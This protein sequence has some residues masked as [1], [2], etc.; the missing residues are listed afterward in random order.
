MPT[1]I[2]GGASSSGIP[3]VTA[4]YELRVGLETDAVNNA[5]YIGAVKIFSENDSGM[6]TGEPY[7]LSPETDD[8]YR[9]R[10]S[11]DTILDDEL[12]NYTSQNTG[13]HTIIA[14]ATNLAP[15]W[16]SGGYNTNPTSV[17]SNTS[18]A[19]LQ[20]YS[21]FPLIGTSTLSLDFECSFT[22]QPVSNTIIDIGFFLG[23]AT[24]PFAPTDGIYFRLTSAG[25][26]GIVN[27]N[28]NEVS[29]GIFPL[30]GGTGTWVYTNS[31]QYQ[32]I[33][34]STI[35]KIEFWVN[36][37]TGAKLLGDIPTPVGQGT[38][39]MST[40]L[41]FRIRH[42][43]AGGAASG[44]INCILTRYNVRI[45]GVTGGSTLSSFSDRCLGSYQGLSGGIIGSLMV[46]TVSSGTVNQPSPA[47]PTN[48]TNT[49]GGLGLGGTFY[50]LATLAAG[51][52][53]IINTYQVPLGT[54]ASQGRRLVVSGVGI[55][56]FVQTVIATGPYCARFYIAFGHTALSLATT[57]SSTSKAPRRIMTPMVQLVTLNQAVSTLVAQTT[58]TFDLS[59][60][61]YVNP[62]EYIALVT[63]HI[64]TAATGGVI[65]H[66]V[67]WRYGWE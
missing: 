7:L 9:L 31:K 42:A 19:T 44:A 37:G 59:D 1:K 65:A 6:L 55:A 14:A 18:G 17:T 57:E 45:G 3:N 11:Q 22:S 8:D 10:V 41:P 36:D 2:I 16:T 66:Q 53:A 67:S 30:S 52:D 56:S 43:I 54:T 49:L 64:G 58:Y 15:S 38:P 50:E 63:T 33:L 24:N 34:Y 26:Q 28:G 23:G 27:Y 48:T 13:K 35:R 4:N 20:T 47:L 12:F 5:Q 61:I 32:F 62:G 46:G 21:M 29:T 25:L 40:S 60:P 51:T 39:Y